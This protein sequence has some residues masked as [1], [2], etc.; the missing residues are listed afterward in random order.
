MAERATF[1]HITDPHVSAA[2]EA[3]ERDDRKVDISGIPNGT[4][5]EVLKLLFQRLAGRLAAEGRS[6]DAVLFSGD[7][8][9]RGGVKQTSQPFEI[10]TFR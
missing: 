10:V 5:Q 3:F 9:N 8:Q 1:L 6:L 4:R 2:G 7:A